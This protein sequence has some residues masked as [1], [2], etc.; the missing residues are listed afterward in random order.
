MSTQEAPFSGGM[1]PDQLNEYLSSDRSPPEC[2]TMSDLDGFLT[3]LAVGPSVARPSEWLP[4]VWGGQEPVFSDDAEMRGVMGGILGRYNEILRQIERGAVAPL[5]WTTADDLVI[6]A[7]WAEGF[8]QAM[9]LRWDDWE[10]LFQSEE[11]AVA[12]FPILALCGDA[13]GESLFGL[14]AEAEDKVMER[15]PEVIPSCVREIAAFWYQRRA[16]PAGT[17][18][19]GRATTAARFTPKVGRNAPCPCGSGRKFKK[20]C[21]P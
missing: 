5:F 21:G 17:P 19:T 8:L 10:P 3:G 9:K 6:A 20:C 11:H 4:I 12:L 14:D 13:S 15:A 1:T 7:D 18:P 2:M 16:M